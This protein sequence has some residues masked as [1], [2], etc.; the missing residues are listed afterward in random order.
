VRTVEAAA[1]RDRRDALSPA[2]RRML[3]GPRPRPSWRLPLRRH[4]QD[5]SRLGSINSLRRPGTCPPC[6]PPSSTRSGPLLLLAGERSCLRGSRWCCRWQDRPTA[7]WQAARTIGPSLVPRPRIPGPR[8]RRIARTDCR[9]GPAAQTKPRR[10]CAIPPW[11][12]WPRPGGHSSG[13]SRTRAKM[14]SSAYS[15]LPS[16]PRAIRRTWPSTHASSSLTAHPTRPS[17]CGAPQPST[18]TST[19]DGKP[20]ASSTPTGKATKPKHGCAT[21]SGR[22]NPDRRCRQGGSR[23]PAENQRIVGC[24]AQQAGLGPAGHPDPS[25]TAETARPRRWSTHPATAHSRRGR[26]AR[27]RRSPGHDHT[28]APWSLAAGSLRAANSPPERRSLCCQAT[29]QW[30]PQ[31]PGHSLSPR[32]RA[33]WISAN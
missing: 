6:R 12:A 28:I 23:W 7:R 32:G 16:S 15:R 13:I 33:S 30:G 22:T 27:C 9:A 24:Q 17:P 20:S 10:C 18:A 29:I 2:G 11:A 26:Q 3:C 1:V 5:R 19:P 8:R 25:R 21:W 14:L 31:A 4:P